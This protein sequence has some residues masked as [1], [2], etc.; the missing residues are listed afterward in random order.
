MTRAA[1]RSAETPRRRPAPPR[2]RCLPRSV[3]SPQALWA[4][5]EYVVGPAEPPVSTAHQQQRPGPGGGAGFH[6]AEDSDYE[7]E[8]D[9]ED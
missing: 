1:R 3:L 4:L 6:L 9:D 2:P 8:E 7:P 5:Y